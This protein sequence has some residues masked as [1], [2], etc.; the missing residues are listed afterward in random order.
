[1]RR[2]AIAKEDFI[3]GFGRIEDAE[4]PVKNWV[5]CLEKDCVRTKKS[6]KKK[7]NYGGLTSYLTSGD[8]K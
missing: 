3:R 5:D 7:S 8:R 4:K 2:M 1:M 6:Q